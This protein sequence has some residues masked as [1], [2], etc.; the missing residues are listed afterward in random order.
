MQPNLLQ[1]SLT[2]K[3]LTGLQGN[4]SQSFNLTV[5]SLGAP[6]AAGAAADASLHRRGLTLWPAHAPE[7]DLEQPQ[8]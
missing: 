1:G 5:L 4:K 2:S 3:W 8:L 7:G 6:R